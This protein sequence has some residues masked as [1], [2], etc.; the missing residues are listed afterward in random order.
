MASFPPLGDSVSQHRDF[1]IKGIAVEGINAGDIPTDQNIA[2]EAHRRRILE[3]LRA[4]IPPADIAQSE[5]RYH[6]ILSMRT[7]AAGPLHPDVQLALH[8]INATLQNIQEAQIGLDR[9]LD[10]L[11]ESLSARRQSD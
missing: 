1:I 6:G 10:A 3:D 11:V 2:S 5:L 8:N 7:N 4:V 9:K